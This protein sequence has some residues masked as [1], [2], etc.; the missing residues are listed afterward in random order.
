MIRLKKK[1]GI[2]VFEP[3][4][5]AIWIGSATLNKAFGGGQSL[6]TLKDWLGGG[7]INLMSKGDSSVT[8]TIIC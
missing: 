8:A 7:Q 2:E 6:A 1:K 4:I 5:L 3:S